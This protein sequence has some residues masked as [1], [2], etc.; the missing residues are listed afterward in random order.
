MAEQDEVPTLAAAPATPTQQVVYLNGMPGLADGIVPRDLLSNTQASYS[1]LQLKIDPTNPNRAEG[2]TAPGN[3]PMLMSGYHN[4]LKPLFGLDNMP[5]P[6]KEYIHNLEPVIFERSGETWKMTQPG[7]LS[8]SDQPEQRQQVELTA[9][10][11][12]LAGEVANTRG[13]TQ[14][15]TEA[16]LESVANRAELGPNATQAIYADRLRDEARSS[17]AELNYTQYA[18]TTENGLVENRKAVGQP[19]PQLNIGITEQGQFGINPQVSQER[20]IGDGLS[21]LEKYFDFV[22]PTEHKVARVGVAQAGQMEQTPEGWRVATKGA[23]EITDTQGNVFRP[24]LKAAPTQQVSQAQPVA[25]QEQS[26]QTQPAPDP[27]QAAAKAPTV[28]EEAKPGVGELQVTWKQKGN[29]VAPLTEMRAYFDSLK[30][31]GVAVGAMKFGPGA[32]GKLMGGFSVSYDPNAPD[33]TKL[34]GTIQG[35][36]KV[37]N[38]LEVVEAPDQAVAR[39]RGLGHEGQDK[40]LDLAFPVREAFGIK[41]WDSLSA[42]LT[43]AP[44]EALTAPEQAQQTAAVGRV[45]QIAALDGRTHDV[46]IRE[47]K[48]L[49]D[50]DTSG[51]PISAFLKNFYE[52]LNGAAKIRQH[53]EVDYEKTRQDLQT[54]LLKQA[55]NAQAPGQEQATASV[56]AT[57]QTVAANQPSQ[58]TASVQ[59][60][61]AQKPAP[62]QPAPA[63]TK[64]DLPKDKLALFG[65]SAE[66]LAKNGQLEKLLNGEK[67]SLLGMQAIGQ[68]G[69]EPVKF[70]GKLLLHREANGSVTLKLDLPRQQLEIPNEIGGQPF[71]PE[72]RKRLET[73]G[74]AGLVRGLRDDKGQVY[75]GYVG[76]DKEMNK[77]VVLPENKVNFKDEIAGVKL[78]PEQSHD[79]REG[80]AVKLSQM[81]RGDGGK[82]FDGTVQVQAAKAG[83]EVKPEAYELNQKQAPQVAQKR[84]TTTVKQEPVKAEPVKQKVRGPR[85]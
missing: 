63:F 44:K 57:T 40:A 74:S 20:L 31:Q 81:A 32:D 13:T 33:L 71:T 56:Q 7:R 77:I 4:V 19:L 85:M 1:L 10:A 27:A 51:N 60:V 47:G 50:V 46:I 11:E 23:L 66:V 79:L 38:G 6:G 84:D 42:Q 54:R 28:A 29:E 69:K 59:E 49:L 9:R 3:D 21:K 73:E 65:L 43:R 64:E 34:E 48:S 14:A 78:T 37:G 61:T 2:V 72:Q 68:E 16:A 45:Q 36:K 35:L 17:L 5:G 55:G 82:P 12:Q 83:V 25:A 26:A 24:E 62:T 80:K 15:T 18:P 58:T 52:H 39:R 67:T 22:M 53:L 75:N 30:E 70:D 76:V 8:F 41:Q